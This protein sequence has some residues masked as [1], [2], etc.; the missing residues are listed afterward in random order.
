MVGRPTLKLTLLL[1]SLCG[2]S[3]SLVV[4]TLKDA[5]RC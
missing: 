2:F 3:I 1:S 4:A 5:A